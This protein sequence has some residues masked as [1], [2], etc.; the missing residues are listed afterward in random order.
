[1]SDVFA[2]LVHAGGGGIEVGLTETQR[3]AAAE[4]LTTIGDCLER[5]AGRLQDDEDVW[6]ESE[7]LDWYNDGYREFLARVGSFRRFRAFPIPPRVAMAITQEW[8]DRH[9]GGTVAKRTN[10]VAGGYY[11]TLFGWEVEQAITG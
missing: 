9:A 6:R 1:M 5:V 3:A 7:L 2:E 4:T 11:Q 8:E 10:A